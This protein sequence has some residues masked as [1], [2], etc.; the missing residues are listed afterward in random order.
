MKKIALIEDD[1]DI[2]FT[3]R[4]NLEREGYTV[5]H[6]NRG[7]DGLFAVQRGA[8]DFVIL[9]LNLPD[10][11]GLTICRELRRDRTTRAIPILMLT[12]R[13][14]ERDRITRARRRR[15]PRQAVQ[16]AR[17][18]GAGGGDFPPQRPFSRDAGL[19]RR[20]AAHRREGTPRLHSWRRSEAGQEGVRAA[21]ASGA[22][23]RLGRVARP[24]PLRDLAD[25][26]RG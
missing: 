10:L 3:I 4:L 6:F 2:A 11:D 25:V 17:A 12:A 8:A 26:R 9:D 24:D 5:S 13:G 18:G 16:H 20:R 22:Q 7:Q 23:P 19:R 1:N 14:S 15:L 21:D